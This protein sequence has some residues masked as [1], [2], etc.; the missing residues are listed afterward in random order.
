MSVVRFSF[1]VTCVRTQ[2]IFMHVE[3]LPIFGKTWPCRPYEQPS[4]GTKKFYVHPCHDNPQCHAL[5]RSGSRD[6]YMQCK[7]LLYQPSSK[8]SVGYWFSASMEY[9]AGVLKIHPWLA[10]LRCGPVFRES[11]PYF[12]HTCTLKSVS[13][14]PFLILFT[15][16]RKI[17]KSDY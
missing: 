7:L 2:T 9:H 5:L 11:L 10:L 1:T 15:R 8:S 12:H 6:I 14:S 4:K 16:L 17:S 3:N 13:Y